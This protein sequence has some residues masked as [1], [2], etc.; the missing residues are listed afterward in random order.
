[1][2]EAND[3]PRAEIVIDVQILEVR[4]DRAKPFGLDLTQL[5]DQR[6]VS[7][8][9]RTRAARPA[10]APAAISTLIPTRVQPEHD[11]ARDLHRRLLPGGAVGGRA[12]PRDRL[13]DQAD[14]QAAAA[15][16]RG[17]EDHAQPGR[18]H[19]GPVDRLHADRDGRREL[20]SADV[21][22]LSAGRHQR[23]DDAA[24]DHRRRRH[25]RP[26]RREQHAL[27]STSTSRDRISRRSARA[28]SPRGCGC[29]TASRTCW[30]ACFAKTSAK[31]LRGVAGHLCAFRS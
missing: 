5:F 28:R 14:R 17:P 25:P 22:H 20:Q 19:S 12:L 16:R 29:A 23:R 10:A 4:R 26:H 7:R 6:G 8:R 15:R 9:R 24:R 11:H 13:G 3:K 27:G 21:V 31:S 1:M 18:R 30:R 2:I